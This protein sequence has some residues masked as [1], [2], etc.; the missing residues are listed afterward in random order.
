MH[1]RLLALMFVTFLM[2][3]SV[4]A[5]DAG[6][7]WRRTANGWENTALWSRRSPPQYDP[8]QV[9]HPLQLAAI[10][11]LG[12]LAALAVW[13]HIPRK[14]QDGCTKLAAESHYY[15]QKPYSLRTSHATH[16]A[17]PARLSRRRSEA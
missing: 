15:L 8:P 2:A 16:P 9:I 3:M 1:T 14:N 6:D 11:V 13:G 12:S 4:E 17:D 7:G 10:Q 5:A